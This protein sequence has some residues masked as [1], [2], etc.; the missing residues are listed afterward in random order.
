MII[1][2]IKIQDV[3]IAS[4]LNFVKLLCA[5]NSKTEM[6]LSVRGPYSSPL[7]PRK[8]SEYNEQIKNSEIKIIDIGNFFSNEQNTVFLKCDGQ[9]LKRIWKKTTYTHEYNPHLTLY[10][11]KNKDFAHEL[12]TLLS[13]RYI[14]LSFS[15]SELIIYD[16]SKKNTSLM[17]GLAINNDI[18]KEIVGASLDML[19]INNMED[20]EKY[21]MIDT[22]FEYLEQISFPLEHFSVH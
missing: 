7:K 1:Y 11:G 8:V 22:C 14:N 15:C 2:A 21:K 9:A 10:D 17:L 18:I 16:T 13:K 5:P 6:H 19:Y 3:K 4:I 12:Y 20:F